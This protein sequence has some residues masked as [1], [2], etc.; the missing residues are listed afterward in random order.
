MKNEFDWGL[1]ALSVIGAFVG[2]CVRLS[3]GSIDENGNLL[4]SEGHRF[5]FRYAFVKIV[6]G[7][8]LA[9]V[10]SG[11]V[12]E[13]TGKE[14]VYWVLFTTF[15]MGYAAKRIL[16]IIENVIINALNLKLDNKEKK[17]DND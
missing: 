9:L 16:P 15:I 6:Q 13:I 5:S 7:V 1:F 11:V 14:G 8:G 4:T 3:G 10:A 2:V 17:D 12:M